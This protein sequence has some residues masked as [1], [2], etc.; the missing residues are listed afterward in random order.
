[1]AKEIQA[2]GGKAFIVQ[3][4]ISKVEEAKRLIEDVVSKN[5][6]LDILVNN[7]AVVEAMPLE[8][9]TP[10]HVEKIF[11]TNL[12]G[13]LWVPQEAAKHPPKGGRVISVGSPASKARFPKFPAYSAA[14]G[15]LDVFTKIWSTEL[16]EKG[17]NVN[18]ANPG[19]VETDMSADLRRDI[20]AGRISK[21]AIGRIGAPSNIA[22]IVAFLASPDAEWINGESIFADAGFTL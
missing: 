5:K 21:E 16:R 6:R 12:Y 1:M 17:V 10:E 4:D 11:G 13:P 9:M 22:D 19:A 20:E 2:A 18:S 7:A 14:K 8:A 15:A 3:A